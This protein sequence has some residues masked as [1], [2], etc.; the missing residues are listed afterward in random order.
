MQLDEYYPTRCEYE[1]LAKQ[2]GEVA[3]LIAGGEFNLIELGA[4]NGEK[5]KLLLRELSKR[6]LSYKYFPIDI[7]RE[8]INKI[9]QT[10]T[11]ELPE[12]SFEGIKAEYFRGLKSIRKKTNKTS[13]VL[14]LGSNIGNFNKTAIQDFLLRLN[15][16]LEQGDYAMIG[17]DLKK[18]PQTIID[19]YDD[20]KGVTKEFHLN[21]LHRMNKELGANFDASKFEYYTTYNPRTGAV[22][23]FLIS[24]EQQD[25]EIDFLQKTFHFDEN[26]SVHTEFSYKF[27]L[28][29]VRELAENSGFKV[30]QNLF[31][32]KHFFIDSIWQ[33]L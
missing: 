8:A 28:R 2:S 33:K 23:S 31:D 30:C 21:L 18:K 13:F 20:A 1:I 16:S 11:E 25:V 27:N 12:V 32:S 22:E 29:E 26:E 14:F 6:H 5:T 3:E 9:S 24:V 10:L 15:D 4:G 7:S 19:A 17:F